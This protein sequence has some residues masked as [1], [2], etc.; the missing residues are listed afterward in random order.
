MNQG[1]QHFADLFA[2]GEAWGNLFLIHIFEKQ[3]D[4]KLRF[5]FIF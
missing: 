5:N 4:L 3:A 2:K 1:I